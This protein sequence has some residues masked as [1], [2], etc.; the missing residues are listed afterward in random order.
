ML[1]LAVGGACNG[2]AIS[3][4][5]A[6]TPRDASG[7][8]DADARAPR[9]AG[10]FEDAASPTDG[11]S[12][13]DG[14][15]VDASDASLPTDADTAE[16]PCEARPPIGGAPRVERPLTA[17][18]L[19]DDRL[20]ARGPSFAEAF[21]WLGDYPADTG[22]GTVSETVLPP[23]HYARLDFRTPSEPLSGRVQVDMASPKFGDS[24]AR[25]WMSI[26]RCPGDFDPPDPLCVSGPRVAMT[27]HF[28]VGPPEES[29]ECELE[30]DQTYYL[31]LVH[32]DDAHTLE[33]T[34]DADMC[35]WQLVVYGG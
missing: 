12:I 21:P 28:S 22:S 19:H 24:T 18:L 17:R 34:C 29:W 26:S 3:G 25:G 32:S 16:D 7:P 20:E 9:D 11:G 33:G 15:D 13:E 8:F 35:G 30:P 1:L 6:G 5:D 14:G 10:E 27:V 4:D 31:N 2:G 23:D